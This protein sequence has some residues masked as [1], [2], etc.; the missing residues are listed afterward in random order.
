MVNVLLDESNITKSNHTQ[1]NVT[2]FIQI[3]PLCYTDYK[4]RDA[5]FS[6]DV[7]IDT[8]MQLPKPQDI[9]YEDKSIIHAFYKN[10]SLFSLRMINISMGTPSDGFYK[11]SKFMSW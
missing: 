5:K 4:D 11:E 8:Y 1:S 2:G 9:S 10:N 7:Y 6:R 3:K